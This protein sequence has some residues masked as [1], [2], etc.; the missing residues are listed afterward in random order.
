MEVDNRV[1]C[2][3]LQNLCALAGAFISSMRVF[4]GIMTTQVL[5]SILEL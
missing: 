2:A 3:L 4:S 1:C 5:K